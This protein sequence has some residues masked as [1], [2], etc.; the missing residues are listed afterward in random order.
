M[1]LVMQRTG[2]RPI[3]LL[4]E[5]YADSRQM[6]ALLLE[7]MNYCVLPVAN[8]KEAV[9]AAANNDIDL[10]VTDFNLPDMTGPSVVRN[11]RKLNNRLAHVPVVMLTAFDG[12]EHRLLAAEAGCNA[13]LIKPPNFEILKATIDRLLHANGRVKDKVRLGFASGFSN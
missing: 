12:D 9:T 7:G 6:M 4:V 13:F 10:V 5:D 8:G 3:I 11:V 2:T 1:V